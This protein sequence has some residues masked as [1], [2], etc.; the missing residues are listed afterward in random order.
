MTIEKRTG[1]IY[2]QANPTE[3][4]SISE[5]IQNL[6]FSGTVSQEVNSAEA[7]TDGHKV[8]YAGEDYELRTIWGD[9]IGK[10]TVESSQYISRVQGIFENIS[11]LSP[12]DKFNVVK[13]IKPFHG[14]LDEYFYHLKQIIGYEGRNIVIFDRTKDV[15]VQGGFSN[16]LEEMVKFLI[17]NGYEVHTYKD[18]VR[19]EPIRTVHFSPD[20]FADDLIDITYENVGGK[21]YIDTVWYDQRWADEEQFYPEKATIDI[22]NPEPEN[23]MQIPETK[24]LITVEN[25]GAKPGVE[26]TEVFIDLDASLA[27]INQPVCSL[28]PAFRYS[29]DNTV[30]VFMYSWVRVGFCDFVIANPSV[31]TT[32]QVYKEAITGQFALSNSNNVFYRCTVSYNAEDA[33]PAQWFQYASFNGVIIASEPALDNFRDTYDNVN[34]T[35]GFY[36]VCSKDNNPIMPELWLSKGGRLE[37]DLLNSSGQDDTQTLRVRV[38]GADIRLDVPVF[39]YPPIDST[40]PTPMNIIGFDLSGAITTDTMFY[41][42]HPDATEPGQKWVYDSS[43]DPYPYAPYRICIPAMTKEYDGLYVT[44]TGVKY[45]RKKLHSVSAMN[46]PSDIDYENDTITVDNKYCTSLK[47]AQIVGNNADAMINGLKFTLSA[48]LTHLSE[49]DWV[50]NRIGSFKAITEFFLLMISDSMKAGNFDDIT[51][52]LLAN[53]WLTYNDLST[54]AMDKRHDFN[55]MLHSEIGQIAGSFIRVR[56]RARFRITDGSISPE[57]ISINGYEYTTLADWDEELFELNPNYTLQDWDDAIFKIE[58]FAHLKNGYKLWHFDQEPLRI[59][60]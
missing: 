3:T 41:V 59:R 17:V 31:L 7:V 49:S 26:F 53:L 35:D 60:V 10:A 55:R 52:E 43:I 50:N 11:F 54:V 13:T 37:V 24:N 44:G 30:Y 42:Y 20:I 57:G 15:I 25:P 23:L 39:P 9:F 32:V 16:V 18:I 46:Q 2:P 56:N 29:P 28:P 21:E 33:T 38:W 40:P 19:I 48:K 1:I 36:T 45:D 14:K 27:S 22:D 6:D 4:W 8:M 51:T 58:K 5:S 47:M 34:N 12:L